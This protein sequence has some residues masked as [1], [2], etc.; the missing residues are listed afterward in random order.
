M[1][2]EAGSNPSSNG[3]TAGH[4]RKCLVKG[5]P[6]KHRLLGFALALALL[7]S[8]GLSG[9]V[10]A[11]TTVEDGEY[12]HVVVGGSVASV[13]TI[14]VTESSVYFGS[15][16]NFLGGYTD[17][18]PGVD[19]CLNQSE[20]LINGARYVGPQ[21]NVNVTSSE[22]FGLARVIFDPNTVTGL[23]NRFWF[24]SAPRTCADADTSLSTFTPDT[25][26]NYGPVLYK[27]INGPL[28]FGMHPAG[29][30]TVTSEY[31]SLDVVIGDPSLN[32]S[33]NVFYVAIAQP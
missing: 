30:G 9:L 3:M 33:F 8:A 31:Y 19:V 14:E 6:V 25:D 17:L 11:Q 32:V 15:N 16:L 7:A 29:S 21:F 2:T 24:N 27:Q 4:F 18:G 23:Q 5:T 28:A 20:T 1:D 12:D 10:S 13:L 26:S 22:N